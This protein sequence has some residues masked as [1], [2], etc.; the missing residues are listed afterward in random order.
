MSIRV[1][2]AGCAATA[3]LVGCGDMPTTPDDG[4]PI[5]LQVRVHLLASDSVE[6][7]DTSLDEAALD[8]VLERVNG[9]W[10]QAGIEFG[11]ER[12]VREQ[13]R[14][15]SDFERFLEQGVVLGAVMSPDSL[16]ADGFD[17]FVVRDLGGVTGG[18]YFPS[19]SAILWPELTPE[20]QRDLAG[21][22]G[23]ILAHEIGHMLGLDHVACPSTGNLM[24][25]RCTGTDPTRLHQ[26]QIAASRQ[27]ALIGRAFGGLG[28][29]GART[30][31]STL[32]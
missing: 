15:A 16:R 12:V 14:N 32:P 24:A 22:G 6:A 10:Q 11:V 19:V 21:F 28:A 17:I 9:I 3:V 26:V 5:A 4:G 30:P 1:L 29:A 2:V 7:L 25:P 20:G 27:Q 23:L 13:A 8:T 18:I 31:S